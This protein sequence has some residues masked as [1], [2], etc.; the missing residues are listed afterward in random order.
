[1]KKKIF[2]L[3][4]LALVLTGC[5]PGE[6]GDKKPETIEITPSA[7]QTIEI[8]GQVTLSAKVLPAEAEQGVVW[9]TDTKSIATVSDGVVTGV[10]AGTAKIYAT[11]TEDR[12]VK[13]Y[14]EVEVKPAEVIVDDKT[15]LEYVKEGAQTISA[16]EGWIKSQTMMGMIFGDESADIYCYAKKDPAAKLVEKFDVGDYVRITNVPLSNNFNQWQFNIS[17]E[18]AVKVE[19]ATTT[20]TMPAPS[21]VSIEKY[22]DVAK[23]TA[24][25][26][27]TGAYYLA[28]PVEIKN[29]YV[30]DVSRLPNSANLDFSGDTKPADGV[31]VSWSYPLAAHQEDLVVD[32]A[33]DSVKGYLMDYNSSSKYVSLTANEYVKGA[34]EDPVAT[35]IELDKSSIE[36]YADDIANGVTNQLTATVKD[37]KGKVMADVPV[38]WKTSNVEEVSVDANGLVKPVAVTTADVTITATV[39]GTE[40]AATC[41]VVVKAAAHDPVA[42]VAID[43]KAGINTNVN[44]G[45][46]ATLSATVLPASAVQSVAWSTNAAGVMTVDPATG[47]I[48]A[49]AEGNATIT[50]KSTEDDTKLDSIDFVVAAVEEGSLTSLVTGFSGTATAVASVKGWV[51]AKGT[52]G[53]VLS[54]GTT[55]IYVKCTADITVTPGVGEYVEVLATTMEYKYNSLNLTYSADNSSIVE[56]TATGE[57]PT[58][59][60]T[61][62]NKTEY[63][64]YIGTWKNALP[65]LVRFEDLVTYVVD[66]KFYYYKWTDSEAP[67]MQLSTSYNIT[68]DLNLPNLDIEYVEGY[69]SDINTSS[70]F[71]TIIIT[72]FKLAPVYINSIEVESH[73]GAVQMELNSSLQM[74]AT[75]LDNKGNPMAAEKVSWKLNDGA[76]STIDTDGL[77]TAGAVAETLTVTATS[78]TNAEISGSTSIE[79]VTDVVLPSITYSTGFESDEGF[80]ATNSY[81]GEVTKGATGKQWKFNYGNSISSASPVY[82]GQQ[83]KL[84]VAKNTTNSPYAQT[85]FTTSGLTKIEYYADVPASQGVV[86]ELQ[87]STDQT[88][89]STVKTIPEGK[90]EGSADVSVSGDLYVRFSVTVSATSGDHRDVHLDKINFWSLA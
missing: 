48:E 10:A 80:A 82:G 41:T 68:T 87:V 17:D 90:A 69:L 60:P 33:F 14:V 64:A 23:Y 79:V 26:N 78:V 18:A 81:S 61:T 86:L 54:D 63:E 2:L 67:A 37:Q 1:M 65:K 7:K 59:L 42:S 73:N 40:I 6:E 9:A 52:R 31:N 49:I 57:A 84:R 5:N 13:S 21:Y 25:S 66:K 24:E 77:I 51:M 35:T 19:A 15:L 70:K 46:K 38:A 47:A 22:A 8:G 27:K 83:V 43:G 36:F 71:A 4:L 53:I 72:D 12:A 58:I 3:P 50:V 34:V 16:I 11:S 89:W 55:E 74:N 44:A 20:K 39:T 75:V 56:A 30:S 62:F 45:H 88:T 76:V 32:N 29:A 28:K 85:L